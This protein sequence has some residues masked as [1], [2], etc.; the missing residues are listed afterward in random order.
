MGYELMPTASV[1]AVTQYGWTPLVGSTSLVLS[2]LVQVV[3]E[4]SVA[5]QQSVARQG[6]TRIVW[7]E[8]I[9]FWICMLLFLL[10]NIVYEQYNPNNPPFWK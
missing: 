8:W 7:I 1:C 5:A 10:Y 2:E 6:E 3:M 4:V 9:V